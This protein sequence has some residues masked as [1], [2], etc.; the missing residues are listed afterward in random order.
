MILIITNSDIKHSEKE[1][2]LNSEKRILFGISKLKEMANE[3][4]ATYD[5]GSFSIQDL[6]DG[7]KSLNIQKYKSSPENIFYK[8]LKIRFYLKRG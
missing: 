6:I 2:R 7:A 5:D 1:L 8:S 4:L 3:T